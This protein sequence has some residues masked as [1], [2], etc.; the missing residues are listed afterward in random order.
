MAR[1][2]A[3]IV[4]RGSG[5]QAHADV[6]DSGQ[7]RRELVRVHDVVL[8]PHQDSQRPAG[9]DGAARLLPKP[10]LPEP[11]QSKVSQTLQYSQQPR[12]F[13]H[14]QWAV[15]FGLCGEICRQKISIVIYRNIRFVFTFDG[16]C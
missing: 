2:R 4:P 6:D 1:R 11:L 10:L 16:K 13:E 3:A 7:Q 5:L 15:K 12:I 9:A 8:G 14:S